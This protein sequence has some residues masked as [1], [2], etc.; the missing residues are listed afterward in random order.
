MTGDELMMASLGAEAGLLGAPGVDF[1]VVA[2]EED[3]GDFLTAEV[4]W[5]SVL[6]VF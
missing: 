4:G 5:L 3:L 2:G 6:G 1:G